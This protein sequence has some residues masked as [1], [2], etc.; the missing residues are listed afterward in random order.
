MR[1]AEIDHTAEGAQKVYWKLAST[2]LIQ[3]DNPSPVVVLQVPKE[4]SEVGAQAEMQAFHDPN[5]SWQF[6]QIFD[7]L[8]SKIQSF[9]K[10]G[11]PVPAEPKNWP[12]ILPSAG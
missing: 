12:N 3:T 1:K 8:T 6:S 7:Y 4:V 9:L 11:A 10:D 2:Q 5:L